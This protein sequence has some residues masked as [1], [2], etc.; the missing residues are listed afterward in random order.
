MSG[1]RRT[2][3]HYAKKKNFILQILL[4]PNEFRVYHFDEKTKTKLRCF[5]EVKK[6]LAEINVTKEEMPNTAIVSGKLR[7]SWNNETVVGMAGKER[8]SRKLFY[9]VRSRSKTRTRT[10]HTHAVLI[11]INKSWCNFIQSS[12]TQSAKP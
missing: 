7:T 9:A 3:R 5:I 11:N 4:G 12:R 8:D 2:F 1:N 6:N 10:P